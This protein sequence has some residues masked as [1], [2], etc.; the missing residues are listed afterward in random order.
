[1]FFNSVFSF[2]TFNFHFV[3][4]NCFSLPGILGHVR[5][6]SAKMRTTTIFSY[7]QLLVCEV[8][9]FLHNFNSLL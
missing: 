4:Y 8:L 6:T 7:V 2:D 3:N 5:E 9:Y 1:M